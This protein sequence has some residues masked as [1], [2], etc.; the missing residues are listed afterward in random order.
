MSR[1]S[2]EFT[3]PEQNPAELIRGVVQRVTFH[4]PENGYSILQVQ[5]G[6]AKDRVTVVGTLTSA[7]VG[8]EIVAQGIFVEHPKYG[9]QLQARTITPTV[10]STQEGIE[11]YLAS[12]LIPG[13]G[14]KTARRLIDHFGSDTL[15]ILEHHPH[16]LT[17]VPGIGEHRMKTISAA[18]LEKNE[19]REIIQ[20]LVEHNLSPSL[21][22]RI[23]D[24]YPENAIEVLH[25][26]PYSLARHMK[27][28]GFATA[29]NIALNLGFSL[30][31]PQRIRAGIYSILEKAKDDGHCYL[32]LPTLLER[33]GSLVNAENYDILE[34]QLQELITE[35]SLEVE[36]TAVYLSYIR[37]AERFVAR[38][39]A[40]RCIDTQPLSAH[41]RARVDSLLNEI[42]QIEKID[43]SAEQR[44][45]VLLAC[46]SGILLVTGGPGCGKTTILHAM[47]RVLTELGRHVALAA[48][49][50]RAAQRMAQASMVAAKTIH[51]L[52]RYDRRRQTFF[53]GPDEP[54]EVDGKPVGAVIIDEASMMDIS[55]ARDLF[56]AIPLGANLVL[57]GDK[58]QL[59]SVGPGRVF[60]DLLQSEGVPSIRLTKL[61]R[62]KSDSRIN[63]VAHQVNAGIP[64]AIPHPDDG[65]KSDAYFLPRRDTEE[66]AALIEEL[67]GER[68]PSSFGIDRK[69]IMVLTPTNRGPL[70]AER[71]N[72]LLQNRLNPNIT[73]PSCT[74]STA[75][76]VFALGDRVCQ[77]VNNYQIDEVGVFNGDLGTIIGV[78]K[79]SYEIHVELWDGRLIRYTR[80]DVPQLSLAYAMTVHRSQGSEVPCVVLALHD[81]QYALLERQLTYTAIT[82][83]KELLVIVGSKKALQIASRRQRA[84]KRCSMLDQRIQQLLDQD[85]LPRE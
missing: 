15:H 3:T 75:A 77:R 57:I 25:T 68:I 50:G 6:R 14:P 28:I 40:E 65:T 51:R 7:H 63:E 81:S 30:E 2:E 20:F 56:S 42:E 59:P 67:V 55:L 71:L 32:P 64:P 53:Y 78:D 35:K 24:Q 8:Q 61:Y 29:D 21:A 23:Y 52:L 13:I 47:V 19:M 16:R 26:D 74:L 39:V 38:F 48:P 4:N 69:D 1:T 17:G 37:K 79:N 12:G 66:L 54:L 10:P 60:A 33:A 76:G 18:L 80:S 27:G 11:R 44:E 62:R 58:D 82:R 43:F 9:R 85:G 83:A 45:A 84:T 46:T 41:A 73:N 34:E 49:T 70:G 36:G 72:E 22:A 5:S 31:S